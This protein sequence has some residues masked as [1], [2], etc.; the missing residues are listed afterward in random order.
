MQVE[1]Y[2]ASTLTER[3]ETRVGS[4]REKLLSS[5]SRYR[6][7][8]PAVIAACVGVV[9][10]VVETVAVVRWENRLARADFEAALSLPAG[11]DANTRDAA[12]ARLAEIASAEP[13][14]V[15]ARRK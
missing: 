15:S 10:S 6:L 4:G 12:R 11:K 5:L 1:E 2:S 8:R 3:S 7:Y 13:A 9:L 14:Q